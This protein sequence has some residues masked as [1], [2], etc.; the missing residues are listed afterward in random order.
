MKAELSP[1]AKAEVEELISQK[2]APKLGSDGLVSFQR[3]MLSTTVMWGGK[4]NG[5]IRC[6]WGLIPPT[7]LSHEA[8]MWLY[9][10]EP[11]AEY[12]FLFVR[13]SQK[14]MKLALSR[15]PRIVGHCEVG[16]DRAIR[17]LRWLGAVFHEPNGKLVPF[18]IRRKK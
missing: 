8:Y 10:I 6:L 1:L 7:L 9:I 11:V 15:F 14:A 2:I 12:E 16:N 5:E 4:V 17:W 3:A 18:S 13:Y